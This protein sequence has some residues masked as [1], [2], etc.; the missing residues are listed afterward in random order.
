MLKRHIPFLFCVIT[1]AAPSLVL[2]GHYHH[3]YKSWIQKFDVN[4]NGLIEYAE[5]EEKI[6]RKFNRMDSNGD[7][8]ISDEDKF[9]SRKHKY[10]G[11]MDKAD[12]DGDG[13][14]SQVEFI[15]T[16]KQRFVTQDTNNDN[17]IS[18]EELEVW[19]K[20]HRSEMRQKKFSRLDKN[21]DGV[22]SKEEFI[23]AKH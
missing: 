3:G 12:S 17:T 21:G 9:Y 23:G 15:E 20:A 1:L 2:S 22:I 6:V 19:Y 8:V 5:F 13:V 10:H 14:I 7:G 11:M 4:D 16:M 18:A